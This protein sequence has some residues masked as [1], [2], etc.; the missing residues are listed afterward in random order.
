MDAESILYRTLILFGGAFA[1]ALA[2]IAGLIW[3]TVRRA[4]AKKAL[5]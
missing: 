1:A 4:R 5:G 3:I 2:A